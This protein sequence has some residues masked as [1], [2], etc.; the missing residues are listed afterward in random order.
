MVHT[1]VR[2]SWFLNHLRM[3]GHAKFD[4][5]VEGRRL[6]VPP[7]PRILS[8]GFSCIYHSDAQEILDVWHGGVLLIVLLSPLS[9][10]RLDQGRLEA[11]E[12]HLALL[13]A[14]GPALMLPHCVTPSHDLILLLF[15]L[16]CLELANLFVA[17]IECN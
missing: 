15:L 5:L 2:R 8:C 14:R 10:S 1:M 6:V 17:V 7:I 9:C 16:L 4:L 12:I 3:L 11:E 13:G